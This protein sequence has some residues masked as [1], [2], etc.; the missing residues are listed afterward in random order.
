M[1]R[2]KNTY[3]KRG[4]IV[5]SY[6]IKGDQYKIAKITGYTDIYV[7]NVLSGIRYNEKILREAIRIAKE[8]RKLGIGKKVETINQ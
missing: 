7:Y 6:L 1:R 5:R 4:K 8:N 3:Q 2:T